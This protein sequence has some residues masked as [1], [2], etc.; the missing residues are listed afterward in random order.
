MPVRMVVVVLL[1]VAVLAACT[2]GGG[3][4]RFSES[5]FV[6]PNSNVY[7]LGPGEGESSSFAGLFF[8]WAFADGDMLNEAID[9]AIASQSGGDLLIN[10]TYEFS[11]FQWPFP[12][13]YFIS[14]QVRGTVVKM[15]IGEQELK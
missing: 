10:G 9:K 5:H 1:S 14:V 8:Q 15:E 4:G 2:S 12:P 6:Y 3:V 11:T 13:L 7:P